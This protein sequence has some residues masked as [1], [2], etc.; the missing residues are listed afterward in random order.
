MIVKKI[1]IGPIGYKVEEVKR[2]YYVN[3]EGKHVALHGRIDYAKTRIQ[4]TQRQTDQMKVST[5]WHEALHGILAQAG[6]DHEEALIEALGYGITQLIQD[7][8]ELVKFT[9]EVGD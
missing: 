6:Q 9:Q 7:N 2:L 5:L 8:P 3:D 4:V 1:Q